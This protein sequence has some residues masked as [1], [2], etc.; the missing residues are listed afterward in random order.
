M[1]EDETLTSEPELILERRLKK[2]GREV[3]VDLLIKWKGTPKKT[4]YGWTP[5]NCDKHI[6]SSST[7]YSK[8]GGY[9]MC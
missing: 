5:T 7:S 2:K 9:V 6:H 4:P 8:V 1:M 3:G